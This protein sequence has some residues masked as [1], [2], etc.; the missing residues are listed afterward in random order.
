MSLERREV[1]IE[2]L[3]EETHPLQI[4]CSVDI[5]GEGIDIPAVSHVLFLRPFQT[6]AQRRLCQRR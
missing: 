2:Q 4:I 3:Q 1:A 5:F 6:I